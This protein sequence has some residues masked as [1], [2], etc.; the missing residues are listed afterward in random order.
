MDLEFT[1]KFFQSLCMSF[2]VDSLP[3]I[4]YQNFA[5]A[6]FCESCADRGKNGT[7]ISTKTITKTHHLNQIAINFNPI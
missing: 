5:A 1:I 3:K 2:L 6:I 4:L 7:G